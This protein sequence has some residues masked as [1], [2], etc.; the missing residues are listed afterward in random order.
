MLQHVVL[1]LESP[2]ANPCTPRYRTVDQ[3]LRS[4]VFLYVDIVEMT[5]KLISCWKGGRTLAVVIPASN[6]QFVPV[7]EA[8]LKAPR[9]E[10]TTVSMTME[11]RVSSRGGLHIISIAVIATKKVF[12]LA[13]IGMWCFYLHI[14]DQK[15]SWEE[16][17]GDVYMG[18]IDGN[19]SGELAGAYWLP[20]L[21]S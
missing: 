16:I 1:P 2:S 7:P 10:V 6:K 5:I 12:G 17:L 21:L 8:G 18:E 3:S 13:S 19:E 20:E 4:L 14:V 11:L 15:L 9:S